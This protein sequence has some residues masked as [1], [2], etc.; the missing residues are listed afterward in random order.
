MDE[1]F[2]RFWQAP[3]ASES[4]PKD[5]ATFLYKNLARYTQLEIA[6]V[7][8]CDRLNEDLQFPSIC[9]FDWEINLCEDYY[10]TFGVDISFNFDAS[11]LSTVED[12]VLFLNQQL[13]SVKHPPN[14]LTS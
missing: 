13:L 10:Q 4:I 11:T 7:L 9:W 6:R 8:P 5:L 12:L 1:W 3:N 14:Q 2:E